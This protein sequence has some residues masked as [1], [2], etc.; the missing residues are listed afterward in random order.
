MYFYICGKIRSVT[1]TSV[2]IDNQG[3][4]FLIQISLHT[5]SAIKE[6]KEVQLYTHCIIKTESQAVSLFAIYGFAEEQ[7]RA[8]FM[9]LISVSGVGNNTAQLILS[10]FEPSKLVQSIATGDVAAL[11]KVKGIGS[12][13][14]QRIII[15]LKDK[16]G[17]SAGDF[18]IPLFEGNTQREESLSALLTLGFSRIPAEKS[19]DKAIKEHSSGATV[20]VIIKAALGYL[21]S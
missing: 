2:I 20:E 9:E 13:T 11:Q 1:P 7:E 6:L 5:Y 3:I 4:G 18:K 19:V 8:L 14:A 17:K 12:K 16:M 15:D 10:S 21:S